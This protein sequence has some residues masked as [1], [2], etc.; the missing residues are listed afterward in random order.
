MTT[1]DIAR[2][3]PENQIRW[4]SHRHLILKAFSRSKNGLTDEQAG[5]TTGLLQKRS[6]YWARCAELRAMGLIAPTG[7]T[8]ISS[9]QQEVMICRITSKGSRRLAEMKLAKRSGK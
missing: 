6:V 9:Q 1:S 8:T 5:M 3:K 7:K 4:G 2:A